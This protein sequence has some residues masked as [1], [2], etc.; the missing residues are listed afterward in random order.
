MFL[1]AVAAL[2]C[3]ILLLDAAS[4]RD[5]L[6]P[7]RGAGLHAANGHGVR[8]LAIGEQLR[9]ALPRADEARLEQGL[10]IHI[11]Q[12]GE[13]AQAN[14]LG[15][16]AERVR[17]PALRD[18]ARQRHLAAFEVRLAA[19]RAMVT[20]ACLDALVTLAGRL[21]GAGAR[22]TAKALAV[23][24]RARSG[25]QVVKPDLSTLRVT[26]HSFFVLCHGPIPLQG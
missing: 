23:P 2:G 21:A 7:R 19:A 20:R 17:E 12:V 5:D 13:L 15:L 25:D 6:L 1:T 26:L 3:A 16:L 24:V 10:G 22:A 18:T 9:R 11:A 14:D 4:G 8:D